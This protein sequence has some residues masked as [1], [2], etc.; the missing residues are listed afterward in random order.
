[1]SVKVNVWAIVPAAGSGSRMQQNTP[2]QYLKI[3][4]KTVLE[5]SLEV[6]FSSVELSALV[7]CVPE[8][9]DT[10][11]GLIKH[12]AILAECFTRQQLLV[13]AGGASRAQ[14]VL[15]GLDALEDRASDD[16]WVMVHDAARPCVDSDDLRALY[17][18]LQGDDVGGLLAVPAKDT[19]KIASNGRVTST[20]NRDEVWH[21][22]TPQMFRFS[23]LKTAL[24]RALSDG[25]S[26]T[27]ESS[28]LE[29]AGFEPKLVKGSQNNIKIT[30]KD[31]LLLAE[32]FLL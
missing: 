3:A 25:F 32:Q 7:V 2:K 9:D 21:A 29:Y 17:E 16:D 6:L 18:G 1:M 27:D 13:V 15:N 8:Q 12:N 30:T 24:N 31:D 28:A 5:L 19:L 11:V 22:L 4:N 26:V 10:A 20:L 23:L 14:S